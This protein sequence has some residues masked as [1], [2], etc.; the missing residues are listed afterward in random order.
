[1]TAGMP[2]KSEFPNFLTRLAGF[3]FKFPGGPE[4]S[5]GSESAGACLAQTPAYESGIASYQRCAE[6]N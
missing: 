2:D 6:V 4:E 3:L 5:K 1:V